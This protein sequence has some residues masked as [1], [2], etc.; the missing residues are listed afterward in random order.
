MSATPCFCT[1]FQRMNSI[2][3]CLDSLV[4][5]RKGQTLVELLDLLVVRL[6]KA[7][8]LPSVEGRLFNLLKESA[9]GLGAEWVHARLWPCRTYCFWSA[10]GDM[11]RSA[12]KWRYTVAIIVGL[13]ATRA[14]KRRAYFMQ[15][16]A[17]CK[18]VLDLDRHSQREPSLYLALLIQSV[19]S[20]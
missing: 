5:I 1:T 4:Q 14:T 2:L 10:D 12:E 17:A 3:R 13:W 11:L 7:H 15:F 20:V 8:T 9:W 16:V 19:L 18:P 6:H